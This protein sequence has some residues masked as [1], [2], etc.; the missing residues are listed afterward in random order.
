MAVRFTCAGGVPPEQ[1]KESCSGPVTYVKAGQVVVLLDPLT[2]TC[3]AIEPGLQICWKLAAG[4]PPSFAA[5]GTRP[6]V[7]SLMTLPVSALRP[8]F[9]SVT[10]P[11]PMSAC[12]TSPLWILDE[13]TA[14]FLSCLVPT[15]LFGNELAA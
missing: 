2:Y 14:L 13:T 7:D 6:R 1:L 15:L 3:A 11:A 8:T 5:S 9:E 4:T 10:A 12:L